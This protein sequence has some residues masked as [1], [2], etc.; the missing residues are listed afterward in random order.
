[1]RLSLVSTCSIASGMPWPRIALRAVAR[2]QPDDDAADDRHDDDPASPRWCSA[3]DA[4]CDREA[5]VEGEVGDEPD[6][7]DQQAARSSPATNA[8]PIASALMKA[9]RA[10]DHRRAAADVQSASKAGPIEGETG[11]PP[12]VAAS[13]GTSCVLMDVGVPFLVPSPLSSPSEG[14]RFATIGRAIFEKQCRR[15][16][17]ESRIS[18]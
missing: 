14:A 4:G 9:T 17:H 8:I 13:V 18:R 12:V 16:R 7:R 15:E 11:S 10:I 2:H 1:M 5:P 6:E 3:G